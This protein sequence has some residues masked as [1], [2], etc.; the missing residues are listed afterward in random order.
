MWKWINS[1]ARTKSNAIAIGTGPVPR[2]SVRTGKGPGV[3]NQRKPNQKSAEKPVAP[4]VFRRRKTRSPRESHSCTE[5]W[6]RRD[7]FRNNGK[8]PSSR[9]FSRTAWKSS[10]FFQW[11]AP[12]LFFPY[13]PFYRSNSKIFS[14]RPPDPHR[15]GRPLRDSI[16]TD[17]HPSAE[18]AGRS[19]RT[20]SGPAF[21]KTGYGDVAWKTFS[22][23]FFRRFRTQHLGQFRD[24]FGIPYPR[25]FHYTNFP[26]RVK[27]S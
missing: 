1:A 22:F 11:T 25:E 13:L 12:C 20:R 19:Q 21:H 9:I 3:R 7:W 16:R 10:R 2:E 23:Q 17:K 24:F 27:V 26:V 15:S 6:N 4:A 8:D 5:P 18:E 14:K